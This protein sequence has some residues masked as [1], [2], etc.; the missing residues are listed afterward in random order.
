MDALIITGGDVPDPAFLKTLAE[1]FGL[2]IAADSGLSAA[3]GAGIEPDWVVGDMDSLSDPG[4]LD[5]FPS[6]RVVRHPVAKDLTDTEL[7]IEL[8]AGQGAERIAI[9]GGGGGRLDH[10]LAMRALFER[11]LRPFEWHTALESVYLVEEGDTLRLDA[12]KD[13]TVS[14]FPL[15]GGAAGMSSEGLAWP[16]SGLRWG[17]GDFGVSNRC[18]GGTFSVRA[19]RGALLV[20]AER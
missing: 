14:V 11:E 4:L 19:G 12:W 18:T 20:A 13:R 17:P 5:H 7:A 15:S 1:R 6:E 2:R 10:T 9:A 3:L 16:L 8:A